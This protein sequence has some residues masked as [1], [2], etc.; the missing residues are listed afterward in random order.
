MELELK[1]IIVFTDDVPGLGLFYGNVLG[2]PVIG[3]EKGWIEFG[4]GA[5]SIAL[6]KGKAM[7]GKRAPKLVFQVKDVAAAR[8][9]LIK[10]GFAALGPVKSGT[11]FDMCD[12]KDPD[13]NA[14]QLSSRRS[15]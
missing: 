3:R 8:T 1:R 9:M 2:L 6:H 5:C 11:N 7:V 12:G 13:G 15:R 14:I 4:G 10:R